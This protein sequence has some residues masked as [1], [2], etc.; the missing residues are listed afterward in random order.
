MNS[1]SKSTLKNG[2]LKDRQEIISKEALSYQWNALNGKT[3][4]ESRS[5]AM[6]NL[7]ICAGLQQGEFNG[8]FFQD[9]DL[10]KWIEA[11]AYYLQKHE[12]SEL[13]HNIDYVVDLYEQIQMDDGYFNTFFQVTDVS[14][15]FTNLEHYHEMYCLGHMIEA[16][17][18]Y[19]QATG[20][21]KLLNIVCKYVDLIDSMFGPEPT[22]S[23]GYPGHQEIEL[24]LVKLYK[25]V[26]QEKYLKLAK[27]FL[28]QRGQ[29][30]NFFIEERKVR[31][32]ILRDQ[33]DMAT[34][35][36]QQELEMGLKQT[37]SHLPII[38]QQKPVGHAVRALYMYSGMA[39]VANLCNDVEMETACKT[40]WNSVV[41]KQMYITGGVGA[42]QDKERFTVDYD[43]PN[44]TG[45]A[46]TCAS[47]ALFLWAQRMFNLDPKSEYVDIMERTLYNGILSGVS[48]DGKQYF[49][50]NPLEVCPEIYADRENNHNVKIERQGWF[51]CCCCPTNLARLITSI[52]NY[53]YTKIENTLYVN[54]YAASEFET[55]YADNKIS[56]I[57]ETQFPW[58][59]KVCFEITAEKECTIAFRIPNWADGYS[60][61]INGELINETSEKNG[62]INITKVWNDKLELEFNMPVRVIYPNPAVRNDMGKVALQRGAVIYC[63]EEAD[64][65]KVLSNMRLCDENIISSF[66]KDLLGGCR[67][68]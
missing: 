27:N 35:L 54:L 44:D 68:A 45:Y 20:K 16:A 17:V 48:L 59:G 25:A 26:G 36:N 66:E 60:L 53:L 29:K 22:K 3:S 47:I 52:E 64:N 46:E 56:I 5:H 1:F 40:L 6:Q 50:S 49:Y 55:K 42:S 39:D 21:D 65:G 9:S 10:A 15:R 57:Q 63:L 14:K 19:H 28:Q 13:E 34:A 23:K 58:S 37:Q 30:P 2:F 4:G 12:D 61:R 11:S 8:F 67:D 31:P 51:G 33:D 24:A 7:K 32:I 18:A 38:K 41:N 62:F 43:L